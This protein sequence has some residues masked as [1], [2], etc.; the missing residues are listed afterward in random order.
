[1]NMIKQF[2][3]LIFI[4]LLICSSYASE[5]SF[6]PVTITD[7]LDIKSTITKK[8]ERIISLAP[9]NTEILF[10]L[11]LGD[12]VVGVTRYDNYP[13]EVGKIQKIGGYTDFNSEVIASLTPDLV[14]GI[15]G[16]P[17]ELFDNLRRLG[18]TVIALN[19][20]SLDEV[21][22]DIKTLG[23]ITGAIEEAD[24]VTEEIEKQLSEI[25]KQVKNL[26]PKRI[27]LGSLE[28]PYYTVGGKN[29]LDSNINFAGGKNIFSDSTTVW[30]VV[31]I[32]EILAR[33][34]EV[35]IPGLSSPP[36]GSKDPKVILEKLRENPIWKHTTAVKEG[37]LFMID[38]D[39]LH[40]PGPRIAIGIKILSEKIHPE[41]KK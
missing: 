23:K 13:E 35:I 39:L 36:F 38:E 15:R 37:N 29:F 22:S 20:K 26:K 7:A 30:P 4:F 24:K 27:Y 41:L 32:E 19:S 10:A 12:K 28:P 18:I 6:K 14:L 34:P 5:G 2:L 25:K 8:P 16:N 9:S 17:T 31:S 11:G 3:L 21:I 1:M 40:R 33:D